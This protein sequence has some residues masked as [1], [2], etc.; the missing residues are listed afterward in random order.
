MTTHP[1][2]APTRRSGRP[3]I[4]EARA[5]DFG[6]VVQ[7][8]GALYSAEHGFDQRFED[9]V[10]TIVA[11]YVRSR[12]EAREAAWIA[13]LDGAPVGSVFCVRKEERLAQL[14]LLLVEPGARHLGVG[15]RLVDECLGFARRAGYDRII[16]WTNSILTDARRVYQRAGFELQ[17]EAEHRSY[18]PKLVAQLWARPL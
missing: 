18:G 5:G 14:R 9:L 13:E 16:L 1:S 4:R 2:P 8:H 11:E 10:A 17:E 15:T 12:D 7:R 3:V 6:W